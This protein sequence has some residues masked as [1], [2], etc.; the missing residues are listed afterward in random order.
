MALAAQ[1][2]PLLCVKARVSDPPARSTAINDETGAL[3]VAGWSL[4]WQRCES[5]LAT[6]AAHLEADAS[7]A[8]T[9]TAMHERLV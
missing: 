7:K 6:E 4:P 8:S 3:D 5:F 1:T 9:G 2:L